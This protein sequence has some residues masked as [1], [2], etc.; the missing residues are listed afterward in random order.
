M[1]ESEQR[2]GGVASEALLEINEV[3]A[4]VLQFIDW[5]E[6]YGETSY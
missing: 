2:N 5:L 1:A 3:Q 4:A 6:Q